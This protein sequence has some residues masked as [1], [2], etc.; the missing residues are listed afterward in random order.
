MGFLVPKPRVFGAAEL[1]TAQ[2]LK[3]VLDAQGV[4]DDGGR[5][6][7]RVGTRLKLG[8]QHGHP[9]CEDYRRAFPG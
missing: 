5:Y 9:G 2:A 7:D 8:H 4:P 6:L 3:A 1:R